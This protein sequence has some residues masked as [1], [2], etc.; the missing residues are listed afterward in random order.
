MRARTDAHPA[1]GWLTIAGVVLAFDVLNTRSL[2][3][4][5]LGHRRATIA[6]GG[7]VLGHLVGVLPERI[8]PF[9]RLARWVRP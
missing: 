1:V 7:V 2:T 6:V 3:S 9:A 8:D 4:Y 5:A